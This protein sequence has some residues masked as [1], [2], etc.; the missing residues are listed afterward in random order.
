MG[1][2]V[3][4]WVSTMARALNSQ[5]RGAALTWPGAGA[6]WLLGLGVGAEQSS[7]D[8]AVPCQVLTRTLRRAPHCV[9][10]GIH[11]LLS[12]FCSL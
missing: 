6:A 1:L 12:W 3:P 7:L 8:G 9:S 2:G 11:C 5:V 4:A 10:W